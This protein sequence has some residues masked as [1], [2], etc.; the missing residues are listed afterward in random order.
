MNS[1]VKEVL[2]RHLLP[3]PR[4]TS[5]PPA[6][7]F[8]DSFDADGLVQDLRIASLEEAPLSLYVQIPS[9]CRRGAACTCD[10][11]DAGRKERA[12]SCLLGLDIEIMLVAEALDERRRVRRLHLDG[13]TATV[14]DEEQLEHLWALLNLSF[15]L[16]PGCELAIEMV[17]GIATEG[18]MALLSSLGFRR[19]S[20]ELDGS[21]RLVPQQIALCRELGFE[22]VHLDL[23]YGVPGH[24]ARELDAALGALLS[25]RPDRVALHDFTNLPR[26]F[27]RD[28]GLDLNESPPA[29]DRLEMLLEA[30]AAL[31]GAGY[32]PIGPD[33]FVLPGDE[34]CAA[35][36]A[37][38]L[39]RGFMGFTDGPDADLIGLGVAACGEVQGTLV[40]SSARVGR[41]LAALSQG[42]L[43]VERGWRKDAEDELRGEII[44]DLLCH[45]QVDLAAAA[46][47]HG[48]RVEQFEAELSD[49]REL[50]RD[51]LVELAGT[52]VRV[53][54]TGR[55]AARAVAMVFDHHLRRSLPVEGVPLRV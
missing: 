20:L 19:L 12:M 48:R 8:H 18:Q 32:R 55:L 50:E 27:S 5:Y 21:A 33:H 22:H 44:G 13:G 26:K 39:H 30:S 3:G 31:S 16:E 38:R 4:Y 51:G 41:Y 29:R 54:E 2:L 23:L 49:L 24:G 46:R 53:T 42:R 6:A 15:D 34:L 10:A 52:S 40:Q 17:P 25:V 35:A 7:A 11:S 37:R 28:R 47:A 9:C 1:L 43:P 45:M 36:D 14:L